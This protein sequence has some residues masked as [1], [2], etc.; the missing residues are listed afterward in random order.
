MVHIMEIWIIKVL[1]AVATFMS[2][3]YLLASYVASYI[4]DFKFVSVTSHNISLYC[5]AREMIY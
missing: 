2:T 1:H 4:Q 3:N 5:D